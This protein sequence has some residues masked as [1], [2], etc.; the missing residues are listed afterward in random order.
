M[1]EPIDPD[2]DVD[3]GRPSGFVILALQT[4]VGRERGVDLPEL[5]RRRE[6][7][8]LFDGLE[9]YGLPRTDPVIPDDEL[10]E[11]VKLEQIALENNPR[12][13]GGRS[14]AQFWRID[15]RDR[16]EP[17][18]E[19]AQDLARLAGVD[20]AYPEA[21]VVARRLREPRSAG[22]A[23]AVLSQGYLDAAPTGVGA[24]AV[25]GRCGSR[26]EDV[27]LVD[28]EEG[29]RLTH[30]AIA[31]HQPV[32]L[33][34]PE[35]VNRDLIGTFVGDHGTATMAVI[36]AAGSLSQ[37]EGVAPA[38]GALRGC[39]HFSKATGTSLNVAVAVKQ[40]IIETVPGDVILLEA[41]RGGSLGELP[42]EID[43]ADFEAIR[44]AVDNNR[45]VVEAAGNG[46]RDLDRWRY[47]ATPPSRRM[48]RGDDITADS[49][50]IMV[51][52]SHSAFLPPAVAGEAAP[53][54]DR[55]HPMWF[56]SNFG[57]R[58]D[59]HAWGENVATADADDYV[60]DYSGT[61]SASAIVAGVAVVAQAM[62]AH[63]HNGARLTAP[64][65]RKLLSDPANGTPQFPPGATE[66]IGSMPDL[67]RIAAA[68]DAVA[69]G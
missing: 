47:P 58:I 28:V 13:R 26:G 66:Q 21:V 3:P 24:H 42:V 54:A 38:L 10:D 4:A 40:A 50:A 41:Q 34:H 22:A 18:E 33:M 14:L 17:P 31:A 11:L 19:I 8:E 56:D 32:V 64:A 1:T 67:V 16:P 9:R 65:M 48:E 23:D 51:G 46:P 57:N 55:G 5:A 2:I 35:R 25:R 39:S 44:L 36:G 60:P 7:G 20:S 52:A 69:C 45:I 15:V 12:R 49:G 53:P 27:T 61:S 30:P 29:W 59:C 62:H 6:L 68:V 63:A 37:V 43:L